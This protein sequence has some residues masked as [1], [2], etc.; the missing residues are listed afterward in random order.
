MLFAT[1]QPFH[2]IAQDLSNQ[3][4][5]SCRGDQ[6][7]LRHMKAN[8]DWSDDPDYACKAG[9][10]SLQY[11]AAK[12]YLMV[13]G[14]GDPNHSEEFQLAVQSLY[15]VAY[16]CKFM[17]SQ[18]RYRVMPLEGLW[19]ADDMA[20]FSKNQRQHWQWRLLIQQ[21]AWVEPDLLQQAL[22]ETSQKQALAPGLR[23]ENYQAGWVAQALHR[24]PYDQEGPLIQ[25]IHEKIARHGE[26]AGLHHEIYLNDRRR[27]KPENLRTL[28]RQTF[29]PEAR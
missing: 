12:R 5:L 29:I 18:L 6:L 11:I 2:K 27:C 23:I 4:V 25:Q 22:L 1:P 19:W 24:G 14:Q 28:I 8:Y 21:P 10:I 13:D 16:R 7:P 9:Q 17:H 26:L 20:A 15:A 3:L